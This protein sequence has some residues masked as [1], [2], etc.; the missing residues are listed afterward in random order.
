MKKALWLLIL[1]V[2][3]CGAPSSLI[4][5]FS[6]CFDGKPTGIDSIIGV[7]GLY[8][9]KMVLYDGQILYSSL[10]LY[11]DGSIAQELGKVPTDS[12]LIQDYFTS[13]GHKGEEMSKKTPCSWGR[14][15]VSNDTIK[16]Q[17]IVH[18]SYFDGWDAYEVHY[19]ILDKRRIIEISSKPIG[20]E[21][22]RDYLEM[23]DDNVKKSK[24]F[25]M[26]FIPLKQRPD[27]TCWLKKEKWFW[28]NKELYKV[29]KKNN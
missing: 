14:Y 20:R 15:I 9:G 24:Y 1:L 11:R 25:P 18:Y 28:C 26:T 6:Y 19:K 23:Y 27:S 8:R 29:W 16:V 22:S 4:N 3:S 13:L 2:C 10:M 17:L 12:A 7:N 21:Y 5:G